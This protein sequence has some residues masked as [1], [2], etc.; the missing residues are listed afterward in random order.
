M[1]LRLSITRAAVAV[2]CALAGCSALQTDSA[3][4]GELAPAV[5]PGLAAA[6]SR[7]EG[8]V[9]AT[10][11]NEATTLLFMP[12]EPNGSKI[13]GYEYD[14]NGDE[15]WRPLPADMIVRSLSNGTTYRFRVRGVNARGPS[16]ASDPSNAIV[17]YGAPGSPIVTGQAN[18][19]TVE[20]TWTAPDGNGRTVIGY[21]TK[22]DASSYS[23]A[24]QSTSF[25]ATF[26]DEAAHT[27]CVKALTNG[28]VGRNES[29]ERCSSV[30]R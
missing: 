2:S 7:I 20:W 9:A 4:L 22:L 25:R 27:L 12:A 8:G 13:T 11:G 29:S 17:P 14:V 3:S 6:P 28:D 16:A 23:A 15:S 1:F 26:G 5:V 21:V 19:T 10:E 18:G 30:S 24:S